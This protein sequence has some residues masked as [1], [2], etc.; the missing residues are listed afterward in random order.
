[1]SS[2]HFMS[3][4]HLLLINVCRTEWILQ[5][6]TFARMDEQM[7]IASYNDS[8][9]LI[10]GVPDHRQLI[11]YNI[12]NDTFIDH[13]T[14]VLPLSSTIQGTGSYYSQL[15]NTLYIIPV[16]INGISRFYTETKLFTVSWPYPNV[17][18]V[19]SSSCLTSTTEYLFVVGGARWVGQYMDLVQVFDFST[20]QWLDNVPSLNEKRGSHSCIADATTNILY[21]IGGQNIGPSTKDESLRTIEYINVSNIG[22]QSWKYNTDNLTYEHGA[23]GTRAVLWNDNIL[24]IGGYY[25]THWGYTN[26]YHALDTVQVINT[27]NGIVSLLPD[28]LS[29]T[30]YSTSAIVVNNVLY[31]FGGHRGGSGAVN[32]WMKY[33][34]LSRTIEPTT[35]PTMAITQETQSPT[36][37]IHYQ[38]T[39]DESNVATLIND[40]WIIKVNGHNCG[41]GYTDLDDTTSIYFD[42]Y[43][44]RC[45]DDAAGINGKCY[46]CVSFEEPNHLRTD[47]HFVMPWWIYLLCS[48]LVLI[49]IAAIIYGIYNKLQ[50]KQVS[51]AYDEFSN[52]INAIKLAEQNME[53]KGIASFDDMNVVNEI[54]ET[55]IHTND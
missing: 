14:N 2:L 16:A 26:A 1:M 33:S 12:N 34:L 5:N 40:D 8:I 41:D 36:Q 24:I 31:V 48:I 43:C 39:V 7:A 3:Q 25:R 22:Q 30:V 13:G 20:M 52:K 23:A 17:V 6:T 44:R 46:K 35:A 28:R 47:C 38:S 21:A 29:Y 49:C 53:G 9:F 45:D 54:N 37:L 4:L 27:I 32:T 19:G 18:G 55:V 11:E 15:H 50:K 10:G 42:V 51:G